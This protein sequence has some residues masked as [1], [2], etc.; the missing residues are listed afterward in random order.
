MRKIVAISI[1]L[2]VASLVV[3]AQDKD[4]KVPP[5]V[6][7]F[8]ES[9]TKAIALEKADL[10]GDGS[11]DFVLV[12]EKEKPAKDADD[13][14]VGQRPLLILLR[15]ADGK[16][17]VAKRNERIVM[18]SQ[19]GGVFG[20]PFEGVIAKTNTFSVEHYGGSSW[21]WKYS[22]KFNYSR[23]DKTWQL[24]RVEEINYHTSNPNKATTKIYTPPK[25]FGKIDI[26]DFDPENYLK[27]GV[28]PKT[29]D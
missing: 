29:E 1:W 25:H 3:A 16:L 8:V 28:K 21:R 4:L 15:G 2:C 5:E 9:G 13:F 22:Y 18:C 23:I 14:P 7:P 20:E 10:N 6:A 19:C 12:L 11:E 27:K 24:V 17:K 26:A